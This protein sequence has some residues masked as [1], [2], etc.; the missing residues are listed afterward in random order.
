MAMAQYAILT[1]VGK[2]RPGLVDAVSRFIL[3]CGGNIEDSRM[4]ILGGEFAMVILVGGPPEAVQKVLR[5][6]DAVGKKAG[7]SIQSHQTS[8]PGEAARVGTIPYRLD[9]YSMDHPGIVQ[10]I[11]H[12]L[13]QRKIN[14]RALDTR[15]S[16]APH[17]GQPLFSLHATIDVPAKENV[18]DIRKQLDAI[19][20][21]ENIDIE[22][23]P[24]E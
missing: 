12:F 13:A 1:A 21:E 22:I 15:L 20:A 9:A 2:D 10:R 7:L 24:A 16:Y 6:S 3:Q 4:A 23:K 11:A 14:I 17:T 19:G 5:E 8:G 18:L